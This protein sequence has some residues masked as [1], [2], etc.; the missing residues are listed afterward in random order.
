M[1]NTTERDVINSINFEDLC[2]NIATAKS[3]AAYLDI[4]N[5]LKADGADS[6]ILGCSEVCLLLNDQ[7]TE[8]P[9][10]DTT[11]IHCQAAFRAALD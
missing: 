1:P 11:H 7:N 6:V 3:E 9:V 8:D 4:L 2:Q 5:S 10:Y